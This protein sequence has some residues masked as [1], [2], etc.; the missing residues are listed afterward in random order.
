MFCQSRYVKYY[1]YY[2]LKIPI[3]NCNQQTTFKQYRGEIL[4]IIFDLAIHIFL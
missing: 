2:C 1:Y 3:T 4:E